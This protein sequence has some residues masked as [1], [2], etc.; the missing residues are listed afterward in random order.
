MKPL[1]TFILFF[2]ITLS[3]CQ[4][5]IKV[6]VSSD[7]VG[8]GE[9]VEV[10]YT[11]E[12]GEGN[13]ISPDISKLPL[14]SGPNTSSSFMIMN[15]KKSSSQ[16][17]SFVFRP[18]KEEIMEIPEASFIEGN[19]TQTIDPVT[20]VVLSPSGNSSSPAYTA[21]PPSPKVNREKRKF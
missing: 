10:I 12:N 15:G 18:V 3:W 11:I 20:I 2:C 17:Y 14:I 19:N 16:S 9:I 6:E 8:V 21:K 13:F 1:V 4:A 5:T 7:T